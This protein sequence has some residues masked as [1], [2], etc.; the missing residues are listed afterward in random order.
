MGD[1]VN[2]SGK[3]ILL[4]RAMKASFSA[5]DA[6]VLLVDDDDL[7]QKI[8]NRLLSVFSIDAVIA[9]SGRKALELVKNTAFDMI[10]LDHMMPGLDGPSTLEQMRLNDLLPGNTRVIALTA[11]ISP[12]AREEYI[13]AG[14]SDYLSKPIEPDKLEALLEKWLPPEVIKR[15]TGEG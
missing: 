5:K 3:R 6:K 12:N 10:F 7:N 2:R 1:L 4:R 8:A 11:T 13:A 15:N 14:F 9:D